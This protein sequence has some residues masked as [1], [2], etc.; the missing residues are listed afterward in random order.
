MKRTLSMPTSPQHQRGISLIEVL[1]TVLILAIGLLGLSALQLSS[2]K[3]NQSAMQRSIAVLQT[4]TIVEGIRADTEAAKAG[5]FDIKLDDVIDIV[6][7]PT[8]GIFADNIHYIWRKE[9]IKKLGPAATSSVD[10]SNKKTCTIIVQWDDSRATQDK[11]PKNQDA[12]AEATQVI[13][14]VML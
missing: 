6:K 2:L 13:T 10:C 4:Y 7:P 14:E 11:N 3:N 1:I 12:Q 9:L 8:S 5:Q